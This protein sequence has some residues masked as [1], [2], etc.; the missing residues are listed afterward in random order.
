MAPLD[1]ELPRDLAA[2]RD[3]QNR[4]RTTRRPWRAAGGSARERG[5]PGATMLVDPAASLD[6]YGVAPPETS[7]AAGAPGVWEPRRL[8][9][10]GALFDD[11]GVSGRR[12]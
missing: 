4:K 7:G 6:A 10:T 11:L 2:G 1:R 3:Q 8:G 5:A 12:T 9:S